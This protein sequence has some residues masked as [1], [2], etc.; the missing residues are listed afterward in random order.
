MLK[1]NIYSTTRGNEASKRLLYSVDI[2]NADG[3]K[4]GEFSQYIATMRGEGI[5]EA[6]P[7]AIKLGKFKRHQGAA[8]LTSRVLSRFFRKYKEL[9]STS[10]SGK[11]AKPGE[12]NGPDLLVPPA[13]GN[14]EDSA[15]VPSSV[16]SAAQPAPSAAM[17]VSK[18]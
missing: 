16:Q 2:T 10:A 4:T 5:P 13:H 17:A 12:P 9:L 8:K 1:I 15:A 14:N 18:I 7:F 6:K 3:D 11:P